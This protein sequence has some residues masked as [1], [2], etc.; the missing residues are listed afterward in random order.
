MKANPSTMLTSAPHMNITLVSVPA[1]LVYNI[2]A[3]AQVLHIKVINQK[4]KET[5]TAEMSKIEEVFL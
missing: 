2:I 1:M 5:G 4:L 3:Y